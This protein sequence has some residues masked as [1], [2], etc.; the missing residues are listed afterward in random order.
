M[1]D[2]RSELCRFGWS[3]V[4]A[5]FLSSAA[6]FFGAGFIGFLVGGA[7]GLAWGRRV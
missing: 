3:I 1:D 7:A 4:E 6:A 5:D 2:W